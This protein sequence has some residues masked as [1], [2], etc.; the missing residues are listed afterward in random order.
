MKTK[1]P[2][3]KGKTFK[4]AEDAL[5]VVVVDFVVEDIVVGIEAVVVVG[6]AVVVFDVAVVEF[7]GTLLVV[8][9][10]VVVV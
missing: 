2:S 7:E 5:L 10:A 3:T 9:V 8:G 1:S 4:L 6:S